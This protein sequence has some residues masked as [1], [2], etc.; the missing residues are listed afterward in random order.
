MQ[1]LGLL[2]ASEA[3]VTP[4][5]LVCLIVD[6]I[7]VSPSM[8]GSISL[9]TEDDV[10]SRPLMHSESFMGAVKVIKGLMPSGDNNNPVALELS[11]CVRWPSGFMEFKGHGGG[12]PPVITGDRRNVVA[13]ISCQ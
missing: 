8:S 1:N 2:E 11:P 7:G 4:D 6:D 5:S 12:T 10:A 3:R 13:K 9:N